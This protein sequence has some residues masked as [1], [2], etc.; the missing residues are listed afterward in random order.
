MVEAAGIEPASEDLHLVRLHAYSC[1][2]TTNASPHTAGRIARDPVNFSPTPTG[3]RM[4]LSCFATPFHPRQDRK[5]RTLAIY[6][7][8][9]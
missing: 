2:Y 4:G 3:V 5:I 1:V 6:A 9:A 7:A 8:R